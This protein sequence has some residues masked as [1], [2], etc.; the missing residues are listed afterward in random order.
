MS[1]NISLVEYYTLFFYTIIA[2]QIIDRPHYNTS[3]I[4]VELNSSYD[5]TLKVITISQ[6]RSHYHFSDPS[7]WMEQ[8]ARTNKIEKCSPSCNSNSDLFNQI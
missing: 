8:Y 6:I 4:I 7:I 1:E 5:L 3:A 2:N